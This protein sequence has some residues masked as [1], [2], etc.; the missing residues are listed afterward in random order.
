[1]PRRRRGSEQIGT[2][3][4]SPIDTSTDTFLENLDPDTKTGGVPAQ[5]EDLERGTSRAKRRARKG[6]T[7]TERK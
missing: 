5:D 2:A 7:S 1:M 6:R 4:F 3:G